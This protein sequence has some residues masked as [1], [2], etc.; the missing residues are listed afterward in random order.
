MVSL[1][2]D[3]FKVYIQI[4]Q[5]KKIENQFKNGK[6]KSILFAAIFVIIF[7]LIDRQ[8]YKVIINSYNI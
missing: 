2:N 8:N 4:G 5:K 3:S 1:N 6:R 7:F